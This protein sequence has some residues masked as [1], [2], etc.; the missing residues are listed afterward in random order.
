MNPSLKESYAICRNMARRA[1]NFYYAFL[2]LP[3][4]Q[5]WAMC[6][7]YGFTRLVDDAGDDTSRDI[8][9]RTALLQKWRTDLVAALHGDT[10]ASPVLPALLDTA[11][12]YQI[13]QEYLFSLIE[14]VEFDL[15]PVSYQT[16]EELAHYCYH[17]AGVVG[18]CCIHVWGFSDEK[19]KPLAITVGEAFQ[20]TN[21]LRDLKED[22]TLGRCYL[23]MED[24]MRFGYTETDLANGVRNE[25]F[26]HLMQFQVQRA[27]RLYTAADE[28]KKYLNPVGVSVLET[29]VKLYRGILDEIEQR[30]YDVFSHRVR[31]ST[32]KKLRF[33]LCGILQRYFPGT[34]HVA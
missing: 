23:P 13:P 5:F 1:G 26:Q 9:T 28:L 29:M 16:Y 2:T 15:K 10:A 7:L 33:A 22:M 12:N 11:K 8:E 14:G 32:W 6:A 3:A 31:L 25:A 24:L 30:K 34:R 21:I 18:L 20:L 4:N 19:A 27:R 17:V